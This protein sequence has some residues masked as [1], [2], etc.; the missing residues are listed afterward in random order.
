[1][2]GVASGVA[3]VSILPP[4]YWPS[5]FPVLNALGDHGFVKPDSF[6]LPFAYADFTFNEAVAQAEWRRNGILFG[7]GHA[8]P[9]YHYLCKD[10]TVKTMA[11]LKGKKT[12]MPGGG[13]ARFSNSVGLTTVSIPAS[14]IYT[15]L[16]RGALECV[17]SDLTALK[18]GATIGPMIKS[19]VMINLPPFFTSAGLG[20]NVPFWKGLTND[21]RRVLMN[22]GARSM[23]RLQM[24]YA[25]EEKEA[26]DWAKAN[27]IAVNEP[28]AQL[29]K[30]LNDWVANGIGGAAQIATTN[31]KVQE[32]E[33]IFK[34]FEGYVAKWEKL[35]AGV[36]RNNEA[37]LVALLKT[38]LFDKVDVAKYG[39]D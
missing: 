19:I 30:T 29:K 9:P 16:E 17:C 31:F 18:S 12:R 38:N 24:A 7:G 4:S 34:L 37:A 23:V 14:E 2:Q 6:V 15:G 33:K 1:L 27:G 10:A 35:L 32:P 21:Q 36:D 11:D 20:Y 3:H 5:Q 39:M 28:D 22:E 8:T 26:L 13:W 25:K